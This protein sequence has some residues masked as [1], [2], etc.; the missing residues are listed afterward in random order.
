MPE[1][2]K[3]GSN[4]EELLQYFEDSLTKRIAKFKEIYENCKNS[5]QHQP[6]QEF[7]GNCESIKGLIVDMERDLEIL[8]QKK[9]NLR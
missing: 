5:M 6:N 8:R 1:Q 7:R 2:E 4:I 3:F 9:A